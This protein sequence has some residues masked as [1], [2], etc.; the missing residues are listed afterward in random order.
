MVIFFDYWTKGIHNFVGLN[1]LFKGM[2]IDTCLLHLGSL[3]DPKIKNLDMIEQINCIDLR[4]YKYNL[5]NAL[6]TLNPSAIIALNTTHIFDRVLILN[7]TKLGIRTIFSM[8]GDRI[9]GENIH[10]VI[11]NT[12][13]QNLTIIGISAYC[14][15]FGTY[16]YYNFKYRKRV[17]SSFIVIK[18]ILVDK[19]RSSYFPKNSNELLFDEAWIRDIKYKDYYK[20]IGYQ[21]RQ[22]HLFDLELLRFSLSDVKPI[23]DEP[24]ILYI[25]DGF[26]EQG[27]Y[28]I[29]YEYL[30][31]HCSKIRDICAKIGFRFIVKLHPVTNRGL[32]QKYYSGPVY[33]NQLES[34]VIGASYCLGISSTV[35]NT[36]L[37]LGKRLLRPRLNDL[38]SNIELPAYLQDGIFGELSEEGIKYCCESEK[39]NRINIEE[40]Q[41]LILNGKWS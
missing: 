20:A 19:V 14:Y 35:L 27:M 6:T 7:A 30:S 26:V 16:I 34:L 3:R 24:Y 1:R 21:D 37:K 10:K 38:L 33:D 25:E 5:F 31:V 4:H 32:F 41:N 9:T 8:H 40:M 17:I 29:S 36:C 22:F 12:K 18:S 13:K 23:I 15:Y 28:D 2:N 11:D 39:S